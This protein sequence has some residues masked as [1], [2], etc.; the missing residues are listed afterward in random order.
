MCMTDCCC[1]LVWGIVVWPGPLWAWLGS[2]THIHPPR[3]GRL[4]GLGTRPPPPPSL[5][6][7]PT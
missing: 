5:P 3:V 1:R 2:H 4:L 6:S 7:G